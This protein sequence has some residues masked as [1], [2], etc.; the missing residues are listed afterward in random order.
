MNSHED[1]AVVGEY[2]SEILE[3]LNLSKDLSYLKKDCFGYEKHK[4]YE[5]R[6]LKE[7]KVEIKNTSYSGIIQLD[8]KR[9]YFS[10]KVATNLFYMLSFLKDETCF[11]YDPD[12]IIDIEKGR[13]FFDILGRLFLNEFLKIYKRGFYKK[14]VKREENISFL[15]GKF[16]INGQIRNEI[17]KRLKFNCRYDDLT[18][19]CI[20]NQI[21]LRAATLLIPLIRFNEK[22]KRDLI[23]YS[24]LLRNEVSLINVLP[25]D[26]DLI[27]YN[28]LND[29]YETIIQ[30]S[31]VILQNYFIRTSYVGASKGFN[32]IVN[33]NRVYEDFITELVKELVEE[34]LEFND[35]IVERQ[36]RFNT[37]VKEKKIITRPDIIL[38]KKVSDEYPIIIDAKYKRQE[39]NAD[40]YQVIAYALAI[41]SAKA[42]FLVYPSDEIIESEPLT[43]DPGTFGN[44]RDEVKLHA[45]K[46]DLLLE[47]DLKFREYI[48]GVKDQ[49][50]RK[51]QF[52]NYIN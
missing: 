23:Y 36:E 4:P 14:Y 8:E 9:L 30:F 1:I 28:R 39:Q 41:P 13:N 34:E 6:E 45:V 10:T 12:K 42:C 44:A 51:L 15:R 25:N 21:I 52:Q 29:Y 35:F 40:Y 38:R 5:I 31:K 49:L 50:K 48:R 37:L 18:Y 20:E 16:L 33:M 32:F 43:L 11:H 19:D 46:V 2:R 17:N 22:L 26:C 24:N 3:D 7:E 47:E 27:Q